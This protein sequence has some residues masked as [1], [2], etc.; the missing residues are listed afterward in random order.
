MK[1]LRGVLLAGVAVVLF[2]FSA[3][4]EAAEVP[5]TVVDLNNGE[6][7]L[8]SYEKGATL[9]VQGIG[10]VDK[11]GWKKLKEAS[12]PFALVLK[13]GQKSIPAGEKAGEFRN[14]TSLTASTVT[15]VGKMA[16]MGSPVLKSVSLE[17]ATDIAENAFNTCEE[18]KE[19]FL[20]KVSTLGNGV[21]ASSRKLESVA[22]P[23]VADIPSRA[24][25]NCTALK[26]L[27]LPVAWKIGPNAFDSCS[28]LTTVSLP[29]V[30]EIG[31]RAFYNANSLNEISMPKVLRISEEAFAGCVSLRVLR[32]ENADP[33]VAKD[34]FSRVPRVTIYSN[35][36]ILTSGNYPHYDLAGSQYPKKSSGS[37]GGCDPGMGF[38]ALAPLAAF[39]A[40]KRRGL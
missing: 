29:A 10:E 27:S 11:E 3:A 13:N 2:L 34:A 22:L 1:R 8:P 36:K 25:A 31:L 6:R 30:T 38:L 26:S 33:T 23:L 32:L 24:F 18:L 9:V 19:V 4:A 35:R 37:G 39:C 40:R 16:F 7:T 14:L 28:A 12:L 17:A 5:V 21:F 20:P 15:H